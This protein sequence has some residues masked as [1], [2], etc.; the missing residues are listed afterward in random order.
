MTE[1]SQPITPARRF[2]W[3][4]LFQFKLRTLLI[5]TTIIAVLLGG[6]SY[7]AQKQR[8]AVAALRSH[9]ARIDYLCIL[10]GTIELEPTPFR[11]DVPSPSQWLVDNVG[12]DY[13]ATVKGVDLSYR[14]RV[15]D[16][17]ME[18][19]Q[20]FSTLQWLRLDN[21]SVT[22]AGLKRLTHLKNLQELNLSHTQVTDAG[23]EYLK[24]LTALQ[25]LSLDGTQTTDAGLE[26]LKGLTA[27]QEIV[28]RNTQITDAGLEHF[29]CL[30]TL[31]ILN[32]KN[33]QVTDAGL[34][35][36]KSLAE[37]QWL[38]LEGAQVTDAGVARL[39]KALPNCKIER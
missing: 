26:Y 17:E 27:L 12:I 20:T 24:G 16:A 10:P 21:T 37:L 3:R 4:R 19:L 32:L 9:A 13:F 18:Y 2:N 23:L 38:I 39:Q 33:T 14:D 31:Q 28:L 1:L 8:E 22:D 34:E 15:G 25:R 36:L 6:W 11:D 35:H 30:P 7:K 5:L 29:K